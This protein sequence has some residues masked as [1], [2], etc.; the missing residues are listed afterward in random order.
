MSAIG[1]GAM[2]AEDVHASLGAVLTGTAPGR[3]SEG[4]LF[5]F[6]STGTALQD[7]AAAA[8]LYER[9]CRRGG[10]AEFDFGRGC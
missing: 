6:D 1:A 9:A 3:A 10:Y 4:Q 5:V 7:V 8:A 2:R